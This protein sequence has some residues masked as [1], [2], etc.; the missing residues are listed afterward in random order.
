MNFDQL[1]SAMTDIPREATDI[2]IKGRESTEVFFCMPKGWK[3]PTDRVKPA[4]PGLYYKQGLDRW[5]VS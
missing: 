2:I 4:P 3:P 5:R 1:Q